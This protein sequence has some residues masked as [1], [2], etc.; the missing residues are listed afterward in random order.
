MHETF[1]ML[2]VEDAYE[3]T[4]NGENMVKP[5]ASVNLVPN[6]ALM[7]STGNITNLEMRMLFDAKTNGTWTQFSSYNDTFAIVSAANFTAAQN[8]LTGNALNQVLQGNT[9]HNGMIMVSYKK[10]GQYLR[11]N[12]RP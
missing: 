5:R 8:G 11:P 4:L 6:N 9:L 1:H 3:Y 10:A 2:G 7:Q 12:E